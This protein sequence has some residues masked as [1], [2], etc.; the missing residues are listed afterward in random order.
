MMN[1]VKLGGSII[2][3]TGKYDNKLIDELI[4]LVKTNHE[5]Y[6][7]VIGGGKLCRK[8]QDASLPFLKMALHDDDKVRHANDWLGIAITKINA[9]YVLHKFKQR[10]GKQVHPE[11]ILDPTRK[12]K[13]S[14]RIYFAGGWKP[15]CS[16][17]KDMMLL[18][19]TYGAQKIIKITNI[20]Y[21]KQVSPAKLSR[22]SEPEKKKILAEAKNIK[23]MSWQQLINLVGT[24]WKPG[25]NTPFDPQAA[26]L[27]YRLR[28]KVALLLGRKE[29]LPKM[30]T[31]RKFKGTTVND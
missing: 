16:T 18:A 24:E 13:S 31:G 8:V 9:A 23:E 29:E 17:D 10:L 11:I 22:L 30:L 7:F 26:E 14:A 6:I 4:R 1:I 15:G 20:E 28:K 12:I 19:E 5:G 3:P 25:L 21:I 27:G 2:N